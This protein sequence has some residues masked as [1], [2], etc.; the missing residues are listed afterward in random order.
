LPQEIVSSEKKVRHEICRASSAL[1]YLVHEVFAK[2]PSEC[3]RQPLPAKERRVAD[4]CVEATT[5]DEYLGILNYPMK[6]P[7]GSASAGCICGK[8]PTMQIN[9]VF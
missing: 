4:K 7:L 6:G 8:P 3:S 5:L 1:S 9:R 2:S